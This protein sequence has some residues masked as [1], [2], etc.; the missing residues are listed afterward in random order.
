M[1]V[2]SQSALFDVVP[3]RPQKKLIQPISI[4]KMKQ[5]LEAT[6]RPT[7]FLECQCAV[8]L[9]MWGSTSM[10]LVCPKELQNLMKRKV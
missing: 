1:A 3:P 2:W 9:A 6:E 10:I 7:V 5:Q 4:E 8:R